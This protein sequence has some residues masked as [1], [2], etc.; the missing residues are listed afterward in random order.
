MGW[1]LYRFRLRKAVSASEIRKLFPFFLALVLF[2]LFNALLA[3]QGGMALVRAADTPP[4]TTEA[5][6]HAIETGGPVILDGKV[7]SQNSIIYSN[8]VAYFD[9]EHFYAPLELL[10]DLSDGT[11]LISNKDYKTRNWPRRNRYYP[12]LAAGMR[13]IVPG[14]VERGTLMAGPDKGKEVIS[15]HAEMIFAGT[16]NDFV[17]RAKKKIL[18]PAILVLCNLLAAV[19][20][21]FMP[22]G[23][24]LRLKYKKRQS[25]IMSSGT[26]S[27]PK[28]KK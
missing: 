27:P 19:S 22:A 7:S 14:E 3:W 9:G 18:F 15:V 24:L 28:G 4:V 11:A 16:H 26:I 8:F 5:A 25:E 2:L 21:V 1:L 17:S 13:V 23:Y 12:H 6:L 10:I 20:M